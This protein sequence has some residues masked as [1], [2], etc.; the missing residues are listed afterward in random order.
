MDS[1]AIL[2]YI[3]NKNIR[4]KTFVVNR[5]ATILQASRVEQWS[6]ISTQ[7][8]PADYASRGQ[9]AS[10]FTQ[11]KVWISGP[12]ES[13]PEGELPDKPNHLEELT[14]ADPEVK[15]GILVNATTV[16]ES[17]DA[18][19]QLTECFSSWI[20]PKKV[21]AWHSPEVEW[22]CLDHSR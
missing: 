2:K 8:N 3:A 16:E 10:V 19:Q 22:I 13:R 21:L 6:Y 11:N 12:E 4:F 20:R 15:K 7:L 17:T 1:T 18:M 5:V 14:V 9:K